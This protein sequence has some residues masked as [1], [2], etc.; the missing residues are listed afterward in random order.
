MKSGNLFSKMRHVST[1][2]RQTE[3]DREIK[4]VRVVGIIEKPYVS[5]HTKCIHA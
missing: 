4:R 2:K 1:Y 5:I 3:N